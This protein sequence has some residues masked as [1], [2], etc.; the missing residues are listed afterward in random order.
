MSYGTVL[1]V[2]RAVRDV[3]LHAVQHVGVE[4]FQSL[5]KIA[6]GLGV[7]GVDAVGQHKVHEVEHRGLSVLS[8]VGALRVSALRNDCY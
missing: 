3:A 2:E 8:V 4:R 1:T 5:G 6:R 7:E